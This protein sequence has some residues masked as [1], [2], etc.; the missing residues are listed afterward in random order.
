MVFPECPVG[1][2]C[3]FCICCFCKL[4]QERPCSV[5]GPHHFL[6]AFFVFLL[7]LV[8]A[9]PRYR[10]CTGQRCW[11]LLARLWRAVAPLMKPWCAEGDVPTAANLN[12]YR[13]RSSHVGWHSDDEPLFGKR[14]EAKLIVSVS[15]GTQA[16]FKWMGK[17]CPNNDGHSRWLGHGDILVMDGQCQDEFRHCTDPGVDQERINITFRWVKQHVASCSFLRTG[18]ACCLPTCARVF[19]LSGTELVEKGSFWVFLASPRCLVHLGGASFASHL[20]CMYKVWVSK[21]CLLL[22]TP[23][24][25]SSVGALSVLPLGSLLGSTRYCL[26]KW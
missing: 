8:R 20:P 21:M 22:D 24:G 9:R 7:V 18:E 25:R 17:F 16:L 14:G 3:S 23:C 5:G 2:Q 11:P 1:E 15:F 19:S 10:P 13:G 6:P 26:S 4:G 12:L